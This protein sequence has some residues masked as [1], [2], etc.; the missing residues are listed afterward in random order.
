MLYVDILDTTGALVL[1][2]EC[3]D[4]ITISIGSLLGTSLAKVS[5]EPATG[6]GGK[7]AITA[8]AAG[9][10]FFISNFFVQIF[11]SI[12]SWDH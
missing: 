10:M 8:A 3:I 6:I 1:H 5:I 9:L 2:G 11:A 7:T 12:P 4:A